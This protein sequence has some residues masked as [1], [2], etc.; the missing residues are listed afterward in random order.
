MDQPPAPE[1]LAVKRRWGAL[2]VDVALLLALMAL[3]LVFSFLGGLLG[4][5]SAYVLVGLRAPG[6]NPWPRL[7]SAWLALVPLLGLAYA[8]LHDAGARDAAEP[9][10]AAAVWGR[11]VVLCVIM[12]G[13]L[14]AFGGGL[15]WFIRRWQ[16]ADSPVE[17]AGVDRVGRA[18]VASPLVSDVLLL[19]AL[20]AAGLF[21]GSIFDKALLVMEN[22]EFSLGWVCASLGAGLVFLR[23]GLQEPPGSLI[24]RVRKAWIA[25]SMVIVGTV[26]SVGLMH[27]YANDS[28]SPPLRE[29][30]LFGAGSFAGVAIP[31]VLGGGL[32]WLIQRRRA[33]KA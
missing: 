27:D 15:A 30:L 5:F 4:L 2:L 25:F 9:A 20:S 16:D 6:A 29:W 19:V 8:L 3:G 1:V 10:S 23:A 13:I 21:L 33:A 17:A 14:A 18:L 32:A 24:R 31:A 11:G 12:P 26:S 7:I 22:G 28:P